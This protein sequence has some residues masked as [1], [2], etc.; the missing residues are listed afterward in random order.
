MRQEHYQMP[1]LDGLP[2]RAVALPVEDCQSPA[3]RAI[4]APSAPEPRWKH[5]PRQVPATTIS[6]PALPPRKSNLLKAAHA[7]R[8]R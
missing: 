2:E 5:R 6:E 3:A 8:L 4:Q 7:R 1:W